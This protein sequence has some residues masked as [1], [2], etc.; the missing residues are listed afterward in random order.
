[1]IDF[2]SSA[3]DGCYS[4]QVLSLALSAH[5]NFSSN[6]SKCKLLLHN[7]DE[8]TWVREVTLARTGGSGSW[9]SGLAVSST[10]FLSLPG[11]R[12]SFPMQ[13][14]VP[15][16]IFFSPDFGNPDKTQAFIINFAQPFAK[17]QVILK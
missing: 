4:C 11:F 14:R 13:R 7:R 3:K 1:M 6:L 8:E 17:Q 2:D 10:S 12:M 16:T 5:Q 15:C 9:L